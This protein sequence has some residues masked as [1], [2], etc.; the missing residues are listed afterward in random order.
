MH[1]LNDAIEIIGKPRRTGDGY[2]VVDSAVARSG[3][4][5]YYAFEL[6]DQFKGRNPNDVIRLYRPPEVIFSD[7]SMASYAHKPLTNDHPRERVTASNWKKYAI[8]HV[9]DEVKQDGKFVRVPMM[10][11]DAD[12]IADVDAGKREWSAGYSVAMEVRD[13]FTPEGEP[14]DAVI[15][16]QKIN[17]IAL[18]DKGRAGPECRIVD[19]KG[20]APVATEN[21]MIDGIPVDLGDASAVKAVL[22]KLETAVADGAKALTEQKAAHDVADAEKDAKITALET[23][24]AE[25]SDESAIVARLEAKAALVIDAKAIH[26]ADYSK[27]DENA[28]RR[29]AVVAVVG[30]SMADK[31]DD[32]IAAR[33][34]ILKDNAGHDELRDAVKN[35]GVKV[36]LDDHAKN[37]KAAHGKFVARLTG[38]KES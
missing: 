38:K 31:S 24:V 16:D 28:I 22:A 37:E 34:D 15:T 36:S 11:S 27:M 21:Y 30:D 17:H 23:K 9:G 2:M 3:I 4:Q 26:D 8:G 10:L 20:G 6:G 12:G 7:E 29:A 35:Q 33:F 18:V 1:I 32:Y 13:G 5:E 14:F 25:L 19:N